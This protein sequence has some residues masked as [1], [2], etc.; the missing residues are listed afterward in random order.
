[1]SM[2][3]LRP[4]MARFSPIHL[5][6]LTLGY[7]GTTRRAISATTL[8]TRLRPF[9][10]PAAVED[11][12]GTLITSGNATTEKTLL[13][14]KAGK[15]AAKGVL[16]RD[17]NATWE[18]VCNHRFPLLTLGLDPDNSDVRHKFARADALTPAAIAIAF[19][20][21]THDITN[22]TSVCGELVWRIIRSAL[23]DVVG[24]GPFPSIDK[25]GIVERVLLAGLAKTRGN[26]INEAVGGIRALAVGLPKCDARGLRK[27]LIRIGLQRGLKPA[28]VSHEPDGFAA[29]VRNIAKSLS[30]PPF[31]GRVAI[32]QV[33]DAYGR[34]HAD[35]G[36]LA[37]FK[38][39][40]VAVAK[41]RELQLGRLDLPERMNQDLRL[42]SEVHW[43]TDTVHFVITE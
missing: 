41:E 17:V 6:A 42:R 9:A 37:S 22:K 32:A 19:G 29:R 12:L 30:T 7:L 33:Y 23:Y 3:A 31:H 40:L 34:V 4:D 20:L 43:G 15:D 35:A 18:S 13:L 8:K 11:T 21:D 14:S 39:R 27:Q 16:G 26:A 5:E 10:D 25:L 1:M 28:K 2:D 24:K 36:S 38:E